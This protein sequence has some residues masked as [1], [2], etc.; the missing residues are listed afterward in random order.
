V[1]PP[2]QVFNIVNNCLALIVFIQTDSGITCFWREKITYAYRTSK[3][4]RC[5]VV[6][7]SDFV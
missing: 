6:V 2:K 5:I 7:K 4:I 1:V 3:T